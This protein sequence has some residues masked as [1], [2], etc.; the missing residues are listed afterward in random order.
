L[1]CKKIYLQSKH[2]TKL[3]KVEVRNIFCI[4]F[5]HK[6]VPFWVG[7]PLANITS[8]VDYRGALRY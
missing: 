3:E 4:S 5:R 2:R 6:A 7:A 1:I 8:V